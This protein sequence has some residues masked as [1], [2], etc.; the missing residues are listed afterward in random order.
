MKRLLV[1]SI[2]ALLVA[3]GV[4]GGATSATASWRISSFDI[5]Y[6]VD[7]EG[8]IDA[9]E[10]LNVDFGTLQKHGIFRYLDYKSECVAPRPGALQATYACPIGSD[11][12]YGYTILSVTDAAGK[13][14]NYEVSDENLKKFIKIGDKDTIVTG[15][16]DYVIHYR[17]KGALDPYAEFDEFY[18]NASGDGWS[19]PTIDHFSVTLNL[20][21]GA[22]IKPLCFQ[23]RFGST[24]AC[25]ASATGSV[26]RFESTRA[27]NPNEQ[28]TIVADWQKG[29]VKNPVPTVV[30][31]VSF[32]DF[33]A[34]DA[35]ELGGMA[36]VGLL[37][38]LAIIALWWANG[39]DR[40]YRSLYYLTNDPTEGKRGLFARDNVVVEYT[41]P[42]GLR[43]AEMGLILDERAD[44]LD[45][46]AT[47]IDLAVR[48]YLHITEIPKRGL[49]GSADW[50]LKKVEREDDLNEYERRLYAGLFASRTTVKMADLK[51]T[52]ME[53]LAR[54][55]E[56][57]YSSGMNR[58]WFSQ[59]PETARSAGALVGAGVMVLGGALMFL[60]GYFLGRTLIPAPLVL[61]GLI[62]I[63]LSRTMARRTATG[64]EALRRVLGF[65]LYISTAETRR[66]EF[67]EQENIF[68]K[69]LPFA[70]VFG[71]V[72][73]W[74]KAFEGLDNDASQST[75]GWY[76][77][78][79]PFQV[80]AFSSG[81]QHFS[82]SVGSTIASSPSSSG[83]GSGS[84]GGSSG[85][86]GGGGG[87]GSW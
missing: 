20:P 41:P 73:K 33:F 78:S 60:S 61:A 30:D 34:L 58:K 28:V 3:V 64:S 83:G 22:N 19:E 29:I 79:R 17:L 5:V 67:N 48:G 1:T 40:A 12:T 75:A 24:D 26:A 32:D 47:I 80:A 21:A 23:G 15:R 51:N 13:K 72:G 82:S 7:T 70:I 10:T 55:K 4:S 76:S 14:L 50:E 53:P 65:R 81:L 54:V 46:T 63:L 16:Q 31:R 57:L 43:P 35:L 9:T 8:T 84:S 25:I 62:L 66:Q 85:G 42:D 87:G 74:A 45:V 69:Y 52:F 18:W 49:F 39:R 71:C 37:S 77:S 11:R 44:T 27:L 6:N 59:K 38:V 2:V 86:G 56:A 68:A 36:L